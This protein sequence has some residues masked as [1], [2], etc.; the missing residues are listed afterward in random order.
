MT[1]RLK[2]FISIA[3]F[4]PYTEFELDMLKRIISNYITDSERFDSLYG[5]LS[6]NNHISIDRESFYTFGYEMNI[7]RDLNF[8]QF[9]LVYHRKVFIFLT[10]VPL[11]QVPLYIYKPFIKAFAEWRLLINK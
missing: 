8:L 7:F 10:Q 3:S 1:H 6:Q 2:R 5:A 4:V 9:L 11:K